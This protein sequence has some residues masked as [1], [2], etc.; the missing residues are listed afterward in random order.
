MST[1]SRVECVDCPAD[2][3]MIA[4]D[5]DVDIGEPQQVAPANVSLL[6][7]MDMIDQQPEVSMAYKLPGL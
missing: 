2:D 1:L 5:I 6:D 7:E 4:E 3:G